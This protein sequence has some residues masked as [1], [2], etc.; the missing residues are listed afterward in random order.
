MILVDTG[1][2]VALFDPAD[3]DH[4]RCTH[5]LETIVEP[6]CST[7]PVLTEA[8]HLLDPGSRGS[9]A[10]MDFVSAGGLQVFFL[11][12]SSLARAF[13]LM[14]Q[15]ADRPMDLADASLVVLAEMRGLRCVFTIDRDDFQT[16]R[17]RQGHSYLSFE[18]LG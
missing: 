16:Y 15:Y 14:V 4:E 3:A 8:F 6:L 1:L 18:T 7:L 11:D 17:I 5:W 9:Q 12:D 10:L 13:E 2:L